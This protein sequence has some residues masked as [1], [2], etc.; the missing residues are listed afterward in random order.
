MHKMKMKILNNND[1]N[2]FKYYVID[3]ILI[4]IYKNG[5]LEKL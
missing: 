3:L 2:K 5:Y 1:F 4:L